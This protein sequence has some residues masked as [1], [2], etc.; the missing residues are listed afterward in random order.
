[1]YKNYI[2]RVLD[3]I[4]SLI[5]LIILLPLLILIAVVIKMEDGQEIFFKQERLGYKGDVFQIIKFR[6]MVPNAES[7]GDGLSVK[8]DKD[9]RITTCGYILRK[10]SLDELPQLINVLKGEMSIVGPRPPVTY[11]PYD[12]FE[13]YPEELKARFSVRPGITGLAQVVYRNSASWNNRILKD[14][15]YVR[16]ISFILDV[17]LILLTIF[18]IFKSDSI[19]GSGFDD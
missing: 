4:A 12:G 1:M 3:F 18:K 6:T 14:N 5:A 2:K 16:N 13:E 10:T 9:E 7:L 11:H 8:S 17:K 15:E 19:Y